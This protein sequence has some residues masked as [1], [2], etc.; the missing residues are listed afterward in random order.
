MNVEVFR[1]E[2]SDVCNFQMVTHTHT[3]KYV[4]KKNKKETT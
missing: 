3:H 2:V 1:D 4:Y